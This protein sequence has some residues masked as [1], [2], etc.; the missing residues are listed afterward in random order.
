MIELSDESL[1]RVYKE[2]STIA[3]VGCSSSWP[4]PGAV[5]PAYIQ[6]CGYRIVPVNPFEEEILGERCVASLSALTVPIDVVN[7]FRPAE[8]APAIALDAVDAG[9][10]CLWIQTGIVSDEAR[11]IACDAGLLFVEDRC[12]GITHGQLGL[13]TGVAAWKAAME[14][15]SMQSS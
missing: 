12:I 14:Q 5:V 7:V 13:G 11:R 3:V 15:R 1:R 8:E 9:A 6:S 4:K 10:R 2:T